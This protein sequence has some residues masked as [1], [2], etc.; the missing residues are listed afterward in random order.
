MFIVKSFRYYKKIYGEEKNQY[1]RDS[2]KILYILYWI[3][4]CICTLGFGLIIRIFLN[5]LFKN[6]I[7]KRKIGF[8]FTDY[9]VELVKILQKLGLNFQCISFGKINNDSIDGVNVSHLI[10]FLAS[11]ANAKHTILELYSS[12]NDYTASFN[13]VRII[14]LCGLIFLYKLLLKKKSVLINFNDHSIYNVCLYDYADNLNIYSV[15]IQHAPVGYHF[16]ALYH[17]LNIL[18]S[19]DSLEKYKKN[20]NKIGTFLLFDIRFYNVSEKIKPISIVDIKNVLICINEIDDMS[21]I[22][23]TAKKLKMAG[24]S[25]KIRPHPRDKNKFKDIGGFDL[26]ECGVIW[27]DLSNANIIL[28]NESAVVLEA[29]F[30]KRLIY[31][32]AFFSTSFDNY[33]FL[34]KKILLKEYN[35]IETLITD[36]KAEKLVYD[37]RLVPYFIGNFENISEKMVEINLKLDTVL[38]INDYKNY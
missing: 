14:K 15:Y 37:D 17:D 13:K 20:N 24:Y 23:D 4:L 6:V 12:R 25:V 30:A 26:S 27:D 7:C 2:K 31:K 35:N 33:S 34:K 36:I 18:F 32:C 22:I 10:I 19:E 1:D 11:L 21:V 38:N 28:T 9:D 5:F 3:L 16:P 8:A 29:I